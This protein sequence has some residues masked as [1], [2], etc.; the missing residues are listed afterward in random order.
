LALDVGVDVGEDAEFVVSEDTLSEA[1]L[2]APVDG[3]TQR[4][5]VDGN[6]AP[7]HSSAE[8]CPRILIEL[9]RQLLGHKS[10][11]N[12][13]D[14]RKRICF[15]Q[16][17]PQGRGN[18]LLELDCVS[19]CEFQVAL[20][21]LGVGQAIPDEVNVRLTH[22]AHADAIHLAGKLDRVVH[23]CLR[24]NGW[25]EGGV[26]SNIPFYTVQFYPVP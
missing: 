7:A 26:P 15:C 21:N 16:I 22:L 12:P 8:P 10:D 6:A 18:A 3:R 2:D 11:G 5:T 20:P 17:Y 25:K 1:L 19:H 9:A 24:S 4:G 14:N 13:L 23:C